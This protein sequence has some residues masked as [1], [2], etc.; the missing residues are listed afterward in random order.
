M[1]YMYMS[2][3]KASSGPPEQVI[4]KAQPVSKTQSTYTVRD[5]VSYLSA[6]LCLVCYQRKL[7]KKSL[8]QYVYTSLHYMYV[9]LY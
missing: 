5:T 2:V 8:V 9:Y 7:G 3:S 6:D 4:K 1:L